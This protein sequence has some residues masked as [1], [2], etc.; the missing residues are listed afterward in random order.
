MRVDRERL[1]CLACSI[2]EAMRR[3]RELQGLLLA[4]LVEQT[5]DC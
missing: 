3:E 4:S 1:T 5:T 2:A